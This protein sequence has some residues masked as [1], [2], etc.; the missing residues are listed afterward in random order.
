[1]EYSVCI[2]AVYQGLPA[3]EAV[4]R[5]SAAGFGAFEFWSWWDQDLDAI[6]A[7]AL[8][9]G[10]HAAGMCTRFVPLTVPEARD[11]YIAGLRES[12]A[13]AKRLGCPMLISQVGQ[14]VPGVP[15]EEQR[16]SIVDGL[17]AC[18]PILEG[19]GVTLTV[20]PLNTLVDHKG[21]FLERSDEASEI[22]RA[23]DSP[24]V[25]M[26]FD[27]YHQQITEGNLID[28]L[29]RYIS[30]IGHVHIAGNPRRHEPLI[31]S[32]VHYPTVIRT[33]RELG[34][35]GAVGLEYFPTR[36]PDEGL[37]EILTQMPIE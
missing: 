17:R 29:T 28:N 25:R 23:V 20:E 10:T 1:M 27:V 13:A 36:D 33:L 21:Y 5:V 19:E 4:R 34:Y 37:R 3:A 16:Q 2:S 22:L 12:V 9:T 15:R 14:A 30:Q 8:E 11:E 24:R 26:L 35:G 6:R 18:A 32:E 31:N 7:A